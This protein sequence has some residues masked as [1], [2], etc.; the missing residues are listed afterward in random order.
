MDNMILETVVK[1]MWD[2]DWNLATPTEQVGT[3]IHQDQE[4]VGDTVLV[5]P[6]YRWM[7][8]VSYWLL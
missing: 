4:A 3:P 2:C 6:S 1:M 8:G 5:W 7:K